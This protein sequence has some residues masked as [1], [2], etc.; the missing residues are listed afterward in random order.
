M[1][2]RQLFPGLGLGAITRDK[3]E[4]VRESDAILQ[5]EFAKVGLDKKVWQYFFV[6]PDLKSVGM[7]NNA[8]VFE[9]LVIIRAINTVDAITAS[10]EKVD[11]NVQERITGRILAE[12]EN[13]NRVCY[14][15]ISKPLATI[16][17]GCIKYILYGR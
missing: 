4:A 1:V 17:F 12:V 2:Y 11:W 6:V 3:L 14:D 15:M 13:V 9:Y 8:S 7:K 10:V 16:E 5:E